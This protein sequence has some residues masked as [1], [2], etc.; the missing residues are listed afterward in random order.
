MSRL[1]ASLAPLPLLKI[2]YA[3]CGRYSGMTTDHKD[4]QHSLTSAT[5]PSLS[6]LAIRGRTSHRKLPFH[7]YYVHH[8]S[9]FARTAHARLSS[10]I[11]QR[12]ASQVLQH[13][14]LRSS[15]R[16]PVIHLRLP[17]AGD[18]WRLTVAARD[19]RLRPICRLQCHRWS[20]P[21]WRTR[22]SCRQ[23]CAILARSKHTSGLP[24]H[25]PGPFQSS[26]FRDHGQRDTTRLLVCDVLIRKL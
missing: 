10:W 17:R 8:V 5:T 19:R 15:F 25:L 1:Y 2:S 21:R 7:T 26:L 13:D 24:L 23:L 9:I 12:F 6:F 16:R 3:C 11:G 14:R 22:E 18:R 4:S 20:S